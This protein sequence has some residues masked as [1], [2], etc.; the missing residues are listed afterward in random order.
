MADF[1]TVFI[2]SSSEGK[3]YAEYLQAALDDYCEARVWDRGSFGLSESGS[4]H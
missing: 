3:R 1:A 2:G 4:K